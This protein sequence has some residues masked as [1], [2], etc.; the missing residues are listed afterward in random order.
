MVRVTAIAAAAPG[1]STRFVEIR[2][3]DLAKTCRPACDYMRQGR[4]IPRADSSK[5]AIEFAPDTVTQR[6]VQ[7]AGKRVTRSVRALV[8]VASNFFQ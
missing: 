8:L 2:W 5:L 6:A 7:P 1:K 4:L 3:S